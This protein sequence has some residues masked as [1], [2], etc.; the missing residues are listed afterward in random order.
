MTQIN[1]INLAEAEMIINADENPISPE[2][3]QA[4]LQEEEVFEH[5]P[6]LEQIVDMLCTK[7]QNTDRKFFRVEV[8]YFLAKMA[9]SMRAKLSTKDR[10][11]IP[12]NIYALALA[13]S[14][15]GKGFSVGLLENEYLGGFQQRFM[16]DTFPVLAEQHLYD[17][18]AKRAAR[19]GTQDAEELEKA[20]KEFK[21]TGELAFTF[22]SG[23]PA[24]VK[25]MRHKLLM[26]KVG[27]INLQVDEIG[28]NLLSSVDILNVFLELYDQGQIKQK[29]TKNTAENQRGQ[30]LQ[31]KTPANALLFGTNSKLLDGGQTEE[32]FYSLLDTGYARRCIFAF[33]HRIRAS[34]NQTAA[35][36]YAELSKPTNKKAMK[37]IYDHFVNLA[38]ITKYDWTIDVP[39]DVAIRL[40]EYKIECERIAD[41]LPEHE[42]IKKTEITHRYFKALKL[43]GTYAFMDEELVLS[44][45]N[46]RSAIKLVEESGVA[47]QELLSREK[48]YMKLA[49]YLAAVG[50]PQTHAD[51]H[52]ALAFYKSSTG[53]RNEMMLLATA[54]GYRQH[55]MI[56]KSFDNGIEFYTGETLQETDLDKIKVSYSDHFAYNYR[57][58]EVPFDQLHEL[59][60]ID[61]YNWCN[62][63]VRGGH[64]AEENV[65]QGFNTI[66]LDVDGGTPLFVAHDLLKEYKFMT[67]TT[68]RHTDLDHRFRLLMPINY[69]LLLD[70]DE[71]GQFMSNL[72]NWL[73]FKVDESANQRCRKWLTQEGT[74]IHRNDGKLMDALLFVPKTQKNENYLQQMQSIES[75]DNLERWFAQ[76]IATGNRNNHMIKY[77]L[78]LHDSGY[79]YAEIEKKVLFFNQQ[80]SNK[81][82]E[83]ELRSTVL[84]TIAKKFTK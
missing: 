44:M 16:E 15:S 67:Y 9:A 39:D 6:I 75:L 25:Q 81:L 23:T 51:L 48:A 30:E 35:E 80:L 64:R 76:R 45:T 68:K 61:G 47:F 28:S 59:V 77:A 2:D 62:H 26:A 32:Q 72:L 24:A 55:I 66:V 3:T 5:H 11:E 50:S 57:N 43:A 41:S 10:G 82:T 49:R 58:E 69:N 71:Y 65:I 36:I 12:V 33:G 78:A 74:Q 56:K 54:W 19:N 46:L 60:G 31:G 53:A 20:Q 7:T 8:A 4:Q 1:E 38:D 34:E 29:L 40:L 14:G 84:L 18:A 79:N 70:T 17:V 21:Q 37:A 63:Y 27:A 83:D 13:P 42:E 52:E 73:P 22:D